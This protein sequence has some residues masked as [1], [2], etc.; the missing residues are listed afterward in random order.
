[1]L[2]IVMFDEQLKRQINN[3]EKEC[4]QICQRLERLYGQEFAKHGLR[5]TVECLRTIKGQLAYKEQL[6]EE[7]YQSS[8][9]IG[10]IN[11]EEYYPNASIPLWKCKRE[12]FQ[13]VGYLTRAN[14]RDIERKTIMILRE[15]LQEGRQE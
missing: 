6:F 10:I 4:E 12:M 8:I 11:N 7:S 14:T 9:E 13:L 2:Q 5:L 3:L 15:M 1:M